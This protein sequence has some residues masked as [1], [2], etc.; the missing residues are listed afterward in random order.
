MNRCP[1]CNTPAH[2]GPCAD[3]S[4]LPRFAC[5]MSHPDEPGQGLLT[6]VAADDAEDAEAQVDLATGEPDSP[7]FGY[8]GTTFPVP[9][10]I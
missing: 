6:F 4:A 1:A 2:S 9:S 3:L 7:W 5:I 8:V 10:T